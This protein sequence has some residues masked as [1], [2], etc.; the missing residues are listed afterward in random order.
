VTGPLDALGQALLAMGRELWAGLIEPRP[1]SHVCRPPSALGDGGALRVYRCT[2]GRL[3]IRE[4]TPGTWELAAV[5]ADPP[6]VT[7][8][9]TYHS[10][11]AYRPRHLA[12]STQVWTWNDWQSS[13]RCTCHSADILTDTW[14]PVRTAR[15]AAADCPVHNP[16]QDGDHDR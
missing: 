4:H 1:T 6:R 15:T 16:R 10:T 7:R 3:W 9:A 11:P 5:H 12:R 8:D 2:C 14:R 13:Q